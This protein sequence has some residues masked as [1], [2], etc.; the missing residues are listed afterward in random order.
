MTLHLP[1][2]WLTSQQDLQQ[3]FPATALAE[4]SVGQPRSTSAAQCLGLEANC[5]LS[6]RRCW[7]PSTLARSPCYWHL[8]RTMWR[9]MAPSRHASC[10]SWALQHV[11]IA[12]CLSAASLSLSKSAYCDC[13]GRD[14]CWLCT[15]SEPSGGVQV[16][17]KWE[18]LMRG[19]D[20]YKAENRAPP[21]T[22]PLSPA[23]AE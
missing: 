17:Q 5:V 14:A 9:Q 2:I 6:C 1:M 22:P 23:Q 3:A 16:P 12:A 10:F 8:H 19:S 21:H 18:N 13:F 15:S 20:V 7:T 11:C 4:G